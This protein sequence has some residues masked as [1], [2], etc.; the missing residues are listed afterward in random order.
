MAHVP[1]ANDDDFPIVDFPIVDEAD[2][3]SL[4]DYRAAELPPIG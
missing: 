3:A 4:L 2:S 1:A